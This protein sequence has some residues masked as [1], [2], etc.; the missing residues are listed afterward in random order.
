MDG[1]RQP[2]Q[3]AHGVARRRIKVP[4]ASGI[5]QVG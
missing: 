1:I 3:T 4:D 5:E 2:R